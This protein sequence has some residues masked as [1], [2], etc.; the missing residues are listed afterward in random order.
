[1]K[2]IAG[3]LVEFPCSFPARVQP[4]GA[5]LATAVTRVKAPILACDHLAPFRA[6]FQTLVSL[7]DQPVQRHFFRVQTAPE[8]RNTEGGKTL[9]AMGVYHDPTLAS[10]SFMDCVHQLPGQIP[11]KS[12][13]D[14]DIQISTGV[15]IRNS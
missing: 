8:G 10:V 4:A 9:D 12:T 13:P 3:N 14:P 15:S 5:V 7:K 11:V 1:M 6:D 2:S